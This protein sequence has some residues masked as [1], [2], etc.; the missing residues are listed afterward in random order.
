[1]TAVPT[2]IP[3]KIEPYDQW[4]ADP[5]PENLK[6][7]VDS[8]EPTIN[9]SLSQVGGVNDPYMRAKARKLAAESVRSYSPQTEAALPTWTT[10]QL[11]QLRRISRQSNPTMRIPE[12]AQLDGLAISRA[13]AEFLDKHDRYPDLDE[14]SD[15]VMLSKKRIQ[16]VRK[17]SRAT[18][19]ES[20]LQGA[21]INPQEPDY[22]NEAADYVYA[23]LDATDRKIL[24]M[25]TGYG[26][27]YK[28]MAPV[29]IAAELGIHESNV[30]RRSAR[31][32]MKINEVEN[33]LKSIS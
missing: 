1:M 2:T 6:R 5:S 29:Q 28:P 31:I 19:S 12:K 8:L 10:Q 27:K 16:D 22:Y 11:M 24:E 23:D 13:E 7:V 26:G 17:M 4:V 20:A 18:P 3:N 33:G 25:K 30:T 32:A 9:Y 14:L 21:T 15:A